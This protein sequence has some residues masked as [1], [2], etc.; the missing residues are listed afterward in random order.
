MSEMRVPGCQHGQA[1]VSAPDIEVYNKEN[2]SGLHL[3]L[4]ESS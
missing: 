1:L 2:I 4:A 3:L